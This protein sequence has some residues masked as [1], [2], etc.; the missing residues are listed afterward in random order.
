MSLVVT[1]DE[2]RVDI[3]VGGG[4][5]HTFRVFHDDDDCADSPPLFWVEQTGNVW[6]EGALARSGD[7]IVLDRTGTAGDI[8][9]F[10]N[11]SAV[12][13]G[14]V[15]QFGQ[16]KVNDGVIL[17]VVTSGSPSGTGTG[18]VVLYNVSGVYRLYL[19][20]GSSWQPISLT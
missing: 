19:Y 15:N 14:R 17:P 8:C 13:I 9:D 2:V 10:H 1:G 5:G 7:P 18:R 11:T 12:R 6:L 3:N 16:M 20:D 4:S